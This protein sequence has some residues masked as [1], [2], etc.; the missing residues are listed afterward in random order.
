M[1]VGIWLAL[2]VSSSIVALMES[3][4]K[5]GS[6]HVVPLIPS[7]GYSVLFLLMVVLAQVLAAV[8]VTFWCSRCCKCLQNR[9]AR[10][11]A[12]VLLCCIAL[13]YA[14]AVIGYAVTVFQSIN[15]GVLQ[16][17]VS[18]T[19]EPVV[20]GSGIWSGG[21]SGVIISGSGESGMSGGGQGSGGSGM[22]EFVK[23]YRCFVLK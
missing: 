19:D 12:A 21:G 4:S 6:G 5:L 11:V 15:Q 14:V 2:A 9:K 3:S 22:R 1:A 18:S 20:S 16:G 23:C 17:N 8:Y 10:V 7:C 13:F